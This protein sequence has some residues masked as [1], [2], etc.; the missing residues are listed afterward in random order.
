MDKDVKRRYLA[1]HTARYFVLFAAIAVLV[2]FGIY[3]SVRLISGAG[4]N[5][6][7]AAGYGFA[8][9]GIFAVLYVGTV[10]AYTS[11]YSRVGRAG[12]IVFVMAAAIIVRFCVRFAYDYQ[13]SDATFGE[14]FFAVLE[15]VTLGG[16]ANVEDVFRGHTL[17]QD[18]IAMNLYV[19]MPVYTALVIITV[20][21]F[22]I[23][24]PM[25][26]TVR[27][28]GKKYSP[29]NKNTDVFIF[30]SITQETVLLAKDV[31]REYAQNKGADGRGKRALILFYGKDI[32]GFDKKNNLHRELQ[33][34]HFIYIAYNHGREMKLA[35]KYP[36]DEKAQDSLIYEWSSAKNVHYFAFKSGQT[37]ASSHYDFKSED[38]NAA[39]A[40]SELAGLKFRL[41]NGKVKNKALNAVY[42]YVL[43]ENDVD[44]PTYDLRLKGITGKDY[45]IAGIPVELKVINE[46]ERAAWN[47][48][49]DAEEYADDKNS[50]Q[51]KK[52]MEIASN[53]KEVR[54]FIEGDFLPALIDGQGGDVIY[55][56]AEAIFGN[57]SGVDNMPF[58]TA[59]GMHGRKPD[60][61]CEKKITGIYS[62]SGYYCEEAAR[63]LEDAFE[64][65][66][67]LVDAAAKVP[68]EN[69]G[70]TARKG[71][72]R[73]FGGMSA[74]EFFN[75]SA[76]T[77]YENKQ[78]KQIEQLIKDGT[79]GSIRKTLYKNVIP[80]GGTFE[81]AKES[82]GSYIPEES[83]FIAAE[84]NFLNAAAKFVYYVAADRLFEPSS[85][86]K[87]EGRRIL[88][89]GFGDTARKTVKA[90]Y[91]NNN[92]NMLVDVVDVNM[93]NLVG[94]LKRNHRGF[95]VVKAEENENELFG[96]PAPPQK[97]DL[98][99][100]YDYSN[101][102]TLQF[103]ERSGLDKEVTDYIDKVM[104]PTEHDVE[105]D[106]LIIA[107]GDD[108]RNIA[109]FRSFMTDLIQETIGEGK[110]LSDIKIFIHLRE[111]YNG[112]RLYWDEETERKVWLKRGVEKSDTIADRVKVIPFG[113][114]ENVFK[115]DEIIR[116]DE[117]RAQ[118]NAYKNITGGS[119]KW[120]QLGIFNKWSSKVSKNMYKLYQEAFVNA[121][122]SGV[123]ADKELTY[124]RHALALLEHRRW[125]RFMTCNGYVRLKKRPAGDKDV[126]KNRYRMHGD[127]CRYCDLGAD[128]MYNEA[129]FTAYMDIAQA[130][131]A[132]IND[133]D[134]SHL[135]E[136]YRGAVGLILK[137][138]DSGK[139]ADSRSKNKKRRFCRDKRKW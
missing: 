9:A 36:G 57:A 125:C 43:S 89:I 91:A 118:H 135:D 13:V 22:A 72:K 24:Y 87:Y 27:T 21:S 85:D 35:K 81:D 37:A 42:V 19:W 46:A 2:A 5:A 79:Y 98:K 12:V 61:E 94:L 16:G 73:M 110:E 15:S 113:Y 63:Y 86:K 75:L 133:G 136:S 121:E 70:T 74:D 92:S 65:Y 108:E 66:R 47:L 93:S 129:N 54:K 119:K 102:L 95:Y 116:D 58:D 103:S 17:W 76:V 67:A 38:V 7:L 68:L 139:A 78:S 11:C 111:R 52:V 96:T 23:D 33:S 14:V 106:A 138:N 41:Q 88:C 114:K 137:A 120:F 45:E 50:P 26:C 53:L 122:N 117:A 112:Y 115:Y 132:E 49:L 99:K 32:E 131:A 127:I 126:V 107:M 83:D 6:W 101:L 20:I 82:F 128:R 4:E 55:D 69:G 104:L 10:L 60:K 71:V 56:V 134:V 28:L 25:L 31:A 124:Y 59:V 77:D 40:F 18:T 84:E 1:K 105:Y 44:Y 97:E 3:N 100:L 130:K 90:L 109:F 48:K 39:D 29:R 64:K 30:N 62:D 34:N 8:A 123:N 51:M 80:R